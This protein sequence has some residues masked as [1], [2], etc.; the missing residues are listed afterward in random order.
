MKIASLSVNDS[1]NDEVSASDRIVLEYKQNGDIGKTIIVSYLERSEREE[2]R[3]WKRK[4]I[5]D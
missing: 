2:A 4:N 3:R 1:A 5:P